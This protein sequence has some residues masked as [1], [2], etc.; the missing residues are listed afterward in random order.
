MSEADLAPIWKELGRQQGVTD[1]HDN[2]HKQ[3]HADINAIRTDIQDVRAKMAEGFKDTNA[4]MLAC[5]AEQ[6]KRLL[7]AFTAAEVKAERSLPVRDFIQER[8]YT[9]VGISGV[10]VAL[11]NW[12]APQLG[13]APHP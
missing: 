9:S 4:T 12:I 3:H 5:F 2:L 11:L 7:A 6:E 1:G 10:I 13:L 8:P